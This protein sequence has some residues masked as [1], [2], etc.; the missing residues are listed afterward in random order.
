MAPDTFNTFFSLGES[1]RSALQ[2]YIE[3]E[4]TTRGREVVLSSI[5]ILSRT[6]REQ[7]KCGSKGEMKDYK[8][9]MVALELGMCSFH[10]LFEMHWRR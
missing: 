10:L 6:F 1:F 3:I 8:Y 9:H 5:Q 2:K 7:F 4:Q